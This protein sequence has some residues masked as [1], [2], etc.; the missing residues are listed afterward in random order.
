MR[1]S[2]L[3]Q[4]RDYAYRRMLSYPPY[5]NMLTVW[6]FADEMTKGI[7]YAGDL[8]ECVRREYGDLVRV[9]GPSERAG[10]KRKDQ[11]CF[12][13]IV[14]MK[15]EQQIEKVKECIE[16]ESDRKN[17]ACYIQYEVD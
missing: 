13:F 16:Q 4:A 7:R 2:Y 3:L 8:A 15:Q 12:S 11:Y 5:V 10:K 14:K 9:V 17:R 6:V 1:H